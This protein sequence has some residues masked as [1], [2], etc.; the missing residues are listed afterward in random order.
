MTMAAMVSPRSTSS[1]SRRW[2]VP[3]GAAGML[4]RPDCGAPPRSITF[5]V[6]RWM[7][8]ARE[9]RALRRREL[10]DDHPLRVLDIQVRKLEPDDRFQCQR[11]RVVDFL[12]EPLA[13]QIL[14][15]LPK[16]PEHLRPIESLSCAVVAEV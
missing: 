8:S 6:G 7:A 16:R 5:R 4:W 12:P 9:I 10:V 1:D 15:D 14:P 2:P 11:H 3:T 13:P